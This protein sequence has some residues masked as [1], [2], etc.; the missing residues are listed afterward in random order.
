[1]ILRPLLSLLITMA[2]VSCARDVTVTTPAPPAA[3]TLAPAPSAT[4]SPSGDDP[5]TPLVIKLDM[6][7]A[8]QVDQEVEVTLEVR[9]Y[10]DAPGASAEIVLPPQARLIS[11]DLKWQGDVRVDAPARLTIR[12]AFAQ[13]GEY[14][15]EATARRVIDADMIWGDQDS[16]FLTVKRD[17]GSFGWESAG[18]PQLSASPVP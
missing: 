15:I 4:P 13:A 6:A 14:V 11:G 10:R 16:I 2:L 8:P 1:M 18:T 3:H 12:L 7:K 5:S 9:A 17:S